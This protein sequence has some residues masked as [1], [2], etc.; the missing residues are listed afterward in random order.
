MRCSFARI[1]T[2]TLT[3][4][5]ALWSEVS[6]VAAAPLLEKTHLFEEKTDGFV[7]YRI[8]CLVV[9]ARGTVLAFCEARKFSGLDWGEIEIHQRRST[10]GGRTFSPARQVAHVGPRLPRNPV[11]A[12]Q[13]PGK[14]I[15]DPGQQ[16]VNNPVAIADRDGTV[17]LIYCVEYMRAFYVRS[18]DDGLT[19]SQPVDITAAADRFRPEWPWR[20]IATGPGHGI[21]LRNGRLVVPVWLAKAEGGAHSNSVV[22][23]IHSDDRGAT[24]QRGDIAVPRAA[25]DTPGTNEPIVAQLGDG[26]VMLIARN[27]APVHRKIVTFSPDGSTGWSPYGFAEALIEPICQTS[28]FSYDDPAAP[29]KTRL[30]FSGPASL[31]S[32]SGAANP[33]SRRARENLSVKLSSDDG[34]TWAATRAL[35][36]GPSAYSDLAVLPDGTIL[37][38][39]E[40][41]R[42]GATRPNSTR[43]DWPY[44]RIT[45]ARFNFAWL[46]DARDPSGPAALP[47]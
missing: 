39:Y 15:G 30:L 22:A 25:A 16:T 8:P 37:C 5:A 23:T 18:T 12:D 21:Q 31:K 2:A 3:L 36:P 19:W 29:G 41:G 35:E 13:P 14:V 45:L 26:R 43:T 6:T 32:A 34:R 47:R 7:S 38:L 42:P 27:H 9:T 40:N 17:H 10:D 24:W 28:L 44:A 4:A 20:V 33:G 11:N 46:T 1:S